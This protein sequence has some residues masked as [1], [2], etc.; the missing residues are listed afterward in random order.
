MKGRFGLR[1]YSSLHTHHDERRC[2]CCVNH[3]PMLIYFCVRRAGCRRSFVVVVVIVAVVAYRCVC[4]F[5]HMFMCVCACVTCVCIYVSVCVY[6]YALTRPGVGIYDLMHC[7]RSTDVHYFIR[8]PF[9]HT[10]S[11]V[12]IPLSR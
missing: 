11:H 8:T 12:W 3:F 6:V 4:V 2:R 10:I 1:A 9:V 5:V 7:M